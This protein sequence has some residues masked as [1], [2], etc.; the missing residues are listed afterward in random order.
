VIN[1][2][3]KEVKDYEKRIRETAEKIERERLKESK[4]NK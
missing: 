3:L 2:I 1:E 4:V